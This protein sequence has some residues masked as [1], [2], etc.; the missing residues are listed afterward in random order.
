MSRST[1]TLILNDFLAHHLKIGPGDRLVLRSIGGSWEHFQEFI[2]LGILET[3]PGFGKLD[4]AGRLIGRKLAS[5][6]GAV[7]VSSNILIDTFEQTTASLFML[8]AMNGAS[9]N[10][11]SQNMLNYPQVLRVFTSQ[12]AQEES[13]HFVR[14][15]GIS[16]IAV[17]SFVCTIIISI[18]CLT[19]FLDYII[20]ERRREYAIMRAAGAKKRQIASQILFEFLGILIPSFFVGLV[21]GTAFSVMFVILSEE[22]FLYSG[23]LPFAIEPITLETLTLVV[24]SFFVSIATLVIGA[25]IPARKAAQSNVA[26]VLK[27]A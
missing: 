9:L 16:G 11:I 23:T 26:N 1:N 13:R 5:D 8:S 25:A 10:A 21:L 20:S 24:L 4:D 22:F 17:V 19:V 27:M 2:V 6:G 7:L 14:F 15:L 12:Y 3:A 18:L